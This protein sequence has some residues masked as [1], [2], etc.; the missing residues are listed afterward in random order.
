MSL[1]LILSNIK[2]QNQKAD[3]SEKYYITPYFIDFNNK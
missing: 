3:S 1:I 2:I